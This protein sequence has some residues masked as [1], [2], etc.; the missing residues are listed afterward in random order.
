MASD[1][2]HHHRK[3]KHK[4]GSHHHKKHKKK[5]KKHRRR[6]GSSDGEER[7]KGEGETS[8]VRMDERELQ[9]VLETLEEGL[10]EVC[11]CVTFIC[12]VCGDGRIECRLVFQGGVMHG[13]NVRLVYIQY[14]CVCVTHCVLLPIDHP[15]G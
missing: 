3:H 14:V 6:E 8:E 9:A 7:R 11:V 13:S 5:R 15:Y 2:R 10:I 4:H 1:D 12:V